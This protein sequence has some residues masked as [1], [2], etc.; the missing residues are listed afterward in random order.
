MK[1]FIYINQ[2]DNLL[3]I[4]WRYTYFSGCST[5]TCSTKPRCRNNI[6]LKIVFSRRLFQISIYKPLGEYNDIPLATIWGNKLLLLLLCLE[7]VCL[8]NGGKYVLVALLF[9]NSCQYTISELFPFPL[10]PD[11][12]PSPGSCYTRGGEGKKPGA[13]PLWDIIKL[14]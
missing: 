11:T 8:H 4:S 6:F 2:L 7:G 10:G 14:S 12:R 3:K 1:C 5:Y 13:G 9:Y